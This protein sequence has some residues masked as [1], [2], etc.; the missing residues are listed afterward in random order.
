MSN[1]NNRGRYI[2]PLSSNAGSNGTKL[3]LFYRRIK[4][5]KRDLIGLFLNGGLSGTKLTLL[6]KEII[7]VCKEKNNIIFFEVL[8][9]W[10]AA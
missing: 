7:E 9:N 3:E 8:Q 1:Y 5:K 6:S 4:H 2:I 10:L